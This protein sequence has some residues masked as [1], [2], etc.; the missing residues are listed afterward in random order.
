MVQTLIRLWLQ[1]IC[2]KISLISEYSKAQRIENAERVIVW[3]PNQGIKKSSITYEYF[4][5]SFLLK[6]V[7]FNFKISSSFLFSFIDL[8][9]DVSVIWLRLSKHLKQEHF[10]GSIQEYPG[11]VLC[12]GSHHLKAKL[13]PL[14]C[15]L[16]LCCCIK[17]IYSWKK[18]TK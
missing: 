2:F 10:S 18:Q 3:S 11:I 17:F 5:F 15:S 16:Y 14:E 13:F 8:Y 4:E 1:H 6:G 9:F 7:R 12:A